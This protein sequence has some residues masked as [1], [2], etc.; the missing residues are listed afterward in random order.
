MANSEP[1]N[2]Q[3]TRPIRRRRL[4]VGV[5]FVFVASLTA[6][7]I[8]FAPRLMLWIRADTPIT[9]ELSELDVW[10][11]FYPELERSNILAD[12]GDAEH[13]DVLLLGGSVLEQVAK[14]I[15]PEDFV[16]PADGQPVRIYNL[17]KSAH[18][19]RDSL[20]KARLLARRSFDLVIVYHGINDARM[21]CCAANEFQL[22][23]THCAWYGSIKRRVA[24]KKI[25]FHEI[26]RGATTRLIPLGEPKPE[27]AAFGR[28][29][30][31]PAAFR[32]NV[33]EIVD[34]FNSSPDTR[35]IV[36]TFALRLP[37]D[38]TRERFEA[39]EL[40]YGSGD[41][42]MVVESWGE[43]DSVRQAVAAHNAELR[44]L[45]VGKEALDLVDFAS[46]LESEP[47]NF[48]DPCHL[49]ATGIERFKQ[50]LLDHV[51][52]R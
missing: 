11:F 36:G 14:T 41:Y 47:K 35:T 40:G 10:K 38:Y 16:E 6:G 39:N 43:P 52:Y 49:T 22:D 29:L 31:T 32:A 5:W 24:A 26:V 23:Y 33:R 46:D 20:L 42:E 25:S 19:S 3:V 48:C 45:A 34:T 4:F 2:P 15:R 51:E 27:S 30:K 18:T 13:F 50:S 37:E 21:N 12:T 28:E 9:G 17:C 44:T 1:A 8:T 7:T